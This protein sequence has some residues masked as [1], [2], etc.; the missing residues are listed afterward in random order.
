[1]LPLAAEVLEAGER[2]MFAADSSNG[3]D[4]ELPGELLAA[5]VRTIQRDLSSSKVA[6]RTV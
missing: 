2:R 5:S 6:E 3:R 4:E 1:V